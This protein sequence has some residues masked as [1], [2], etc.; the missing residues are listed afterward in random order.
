LAHL[1]G[2]TWPDLC[3]YEEEFLTV[4][5]PEFHREYL[6]LNYKR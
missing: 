3:T 2:V 6:R 1:L 5:Q 4:K